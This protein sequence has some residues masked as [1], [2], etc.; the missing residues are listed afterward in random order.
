MEAS[1]D[2]NKLLDLLLETLPKE[3]R[4]LDSS[5]NS[6]F[7][8]NGDMILCPSESSCGVVADFLQNVFRNSSLVVQ[9]G[10]YDPVEDHNNC[11]CDKY[12]GF[13]YISFE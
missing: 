4:N 13:Y 5:N 6:G 7:W 12:T 9:T 11:E 8:S 3:P 10:Y 2:M 1:G